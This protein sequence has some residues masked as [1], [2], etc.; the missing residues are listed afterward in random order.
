MKFELGIESK[1][2]SRRP[3]VLPFALAP[4]APPEPCPFS[5][6]N[7]GRRE[8]ISPKGF[9]IL[10]EAWKWGDSATTPRQRA[11]SGSA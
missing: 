1:Q 9:V 11:A 4:N 6:P 7:P 3:Q 10:C 2:A 8:V 5:K